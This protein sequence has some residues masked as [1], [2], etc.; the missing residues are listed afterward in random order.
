[1]HTE[2]SVY[3]SIYM[4]NV[5]MYK[6]NTTASKFLRLFYTYASKFN[7]FFLIYIIYFQ[8]ILTSC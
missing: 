7:N 5:H 2:T 3:Y 6:C 1:M 4:Y 8:N